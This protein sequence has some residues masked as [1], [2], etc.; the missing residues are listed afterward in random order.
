MSVGVRGS[1]PVKVN[2]DVSLN[3]LSAVSATFNLKRRLSINHDLSDDRFLTRVGLFFEFLQTVLETGHLIPDSSR[4]RP[5]C[6]ISTI[7]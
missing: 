4:R 5:L 1:N 6:K 3:A 2:A 7:V